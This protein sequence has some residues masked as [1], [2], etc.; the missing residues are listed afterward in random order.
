MPSQIQSVHV[1]IMLYVHHVNLQK[2]L[3]RFFFCTLNQNP[4]VN[5]RILYYKKTTRLV[6]RTAEYK[7]TSLINVFT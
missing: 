7:T 6:K 1:H 5:A 3:L 4:G 2:S